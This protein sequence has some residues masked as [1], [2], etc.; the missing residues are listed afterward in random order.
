MRRPIHDFRPV[1]LVLL[2]AGCGG[3]QEG[4]V[5]AAE[6][7]ETLETGRDCATAATS[8]GVGRCVAEIDN[9]CDTPV[10][11][12]LHVGSLC[13]TDGG[14]H[15]PANATSE[16][17]TMLSGAKQQLEAEVSCGQGTPLTTLVDGVDCI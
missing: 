1:L 13:K 6:G 3:S 10:T 8:C 4:P 11:C 5:V 2:V 16:R 9:R 7:P 15:G 17:L 14:E 12:Q